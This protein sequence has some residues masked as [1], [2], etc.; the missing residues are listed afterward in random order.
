M[1]WY[2]KYPF[3]L[4][5]LLLVAGLSFLIWKSLIRPFLP[6]EKKPEA[7]PT[8]VALAPDLPVPPSLPDM[9]QA[10]GLQTAP[11]TPR[12]ANANQIQS[13]SPSPV[14]LPK[15]LSTELARLSA[16]LENDPLNARESAKQL[17]TSTRCQE[18]DERWQAIAQ[19]IDR[20]N[21]IFMNSTAPCPEKHPHTVGKGDTLSL[22]AKT[23]QTTVGGLQRI[24]TLKKTSSLIRPGQVFQYLSGQWKITV[25]K[26]HFLLALY[27]DGTLYRIW[28]I[29]TGRQNRTPPGTFVIHNKIIHPAW[30]YEGQNIPYGDP[31]NILGPRWMGLKP[32]GNTDQALRGFGI[33]GTT[34]PNSIGTASSLGCVRMNNDDVEELFDFIPEPS[35]KSSPTEVYIFE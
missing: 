34:E 24:N 11:Q 6:V 17:L 15:E 2:Y 30:T 25:S 31:R 33:H 18:F 28:R 14:P 12:P 23:H 35:S 3:L 22:I 19:I 10:G 9:P 13:F 29:G 27:L 1:Y 8:A 5:G 16:L 21:A 20:A 7:A 32:T 4:I 26:R